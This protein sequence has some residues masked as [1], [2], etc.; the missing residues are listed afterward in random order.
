MKNR[1]DQKFKELKRQ[2]KKALILFIT[3]GDPSLAFNEKLVLQF[4]KDSVDMVELGVP[5]SDPLADGP[6]IQESS[7]R[8]LL[9]RTTLS[10][11]LT[12][13][14]KIREKSE[15]PLL[16]MSYLNPILHFG[17]ERFARSARKAGVDGLIVPDLPPEEETYL[18][19]LLRRHGINLVYFLA[20]TSTA[21][22]RRAVY[23]KARGFIYYV[24]LT[25]VTGARRGLAATLEKNLSRIKKETR[26][27]V[28][29]GFG[30]SD[31]AAARQAAWWA[32]GVIV[33][34]A[35][36]RE[37]DARTPSSST[38]FS[39]KFVRPFSKALRTHA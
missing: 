38:S 1:I 9:R 33:G 24:S 32:D 8:A 25:G 3:A 28:C 29:V 16:L 27:P 19:P 18:A 34:S 7:R 10:K 39:K 23:R 11:I 22:R 36:V 20:P 31:P 2:K 30:I 26:I 4:E 17:P 15:I 13:V 14:G 12:T 21:R 35:I 37:L 5:F 6:V